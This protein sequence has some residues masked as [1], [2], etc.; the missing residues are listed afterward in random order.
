MKIVVLCIII[1]ET[2]KYNLF[3][4][5]FLKHKN[6]YIKFLALLKLLDAQTNLFKNTK[7]I[8]K[9]ELESNRKDY[10]LIRSF[11]VKFI[12]IQ[13]RSPPRILSFEI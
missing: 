8:L 2:I 11:F 5:K 10:T 4:S 13:C 12:I 9:G 1:K 6:Y 3:F 7:Y